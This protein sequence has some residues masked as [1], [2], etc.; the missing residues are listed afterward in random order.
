MF[1][2]I[3]LI[4]FPNFVMFSFYIVLDVFFG[5]GIEK[6]GR[7]PIYRTS[8]SEYGYYKPSEHTIPHR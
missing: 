5:Y 7:N 3:Y 2:I 1:S 8:N 4:M 6:G